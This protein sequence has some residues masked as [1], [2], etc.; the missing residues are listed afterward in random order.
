VAEERLMSS[1]ASEVR[2]NAAIAVVLSGGDSDGSLGIQS[3]KHSGG[4]TFAQ[5]PESARVPSMPKNAIETGCIDFVLRPI[6]I[7]KELTRLRHHPYLHAGPDAAIDSAPEDSAGESER[8]FRHEFRRL[9]I[10]H[11]V[12]FSLYK[13][14]ALQRLLGRRMAVRKV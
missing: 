2:G 4:I 6:A 8:D 9:G 13:R 5:N 3:I 10:A 1:Q 12:D 7:A 14:S 11:G